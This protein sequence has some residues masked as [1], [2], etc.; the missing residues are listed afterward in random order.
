MIDPAPCNSTELDGFPRLRRH[1][2]EHERW[3]KLV[4]DGYRPRE[5]KVR[6]KLAKSGHPLLIGDAVEG[7]LKRVGITKERV[8]DWLGK[9][10]N[11]PARKK[12]MNEWDLWFRHAAKLVSDEEYA[13]AKQ[14]LEEILT[15][16]T[17]AQV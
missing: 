4:R 15:Y 13:I 14:R 2:L 8:S 3:N 6:P 10:C 12:R 7:V 11:C 5:R 17:Q 16:E 1:C 9:P